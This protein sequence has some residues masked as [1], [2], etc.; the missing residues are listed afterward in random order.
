M[1]NDLEGTSGVFVTSVPDGLT[2][3]INGDGYVNV[4]DLQALATAWGSQAG[5]PSSANWNADADLNSDGYVNVGDLQILVANWG[6]ERLTD[7][8]GLRKIRH[9]QASCQW[10]PIS[11]MVASAAR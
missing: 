9:W 5:P 3:D 10:H 4:G 6:R 2:G 8:V 7:I 1:F 11:P